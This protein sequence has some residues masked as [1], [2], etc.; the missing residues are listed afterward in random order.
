[1]GQPVLFIHGGPGGGCS[2]KH[3]QFFDPNFYRII[4]FDQ[5]GAGRSEPHACL[6]NNTT[7]H[8]VED[9]EALRRHLEIESWVLFGGSWGSTLALI[10]AQSYPQVVKALILRGIFLCR[11]QDID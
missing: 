5:R 8:L 9:I 6:Q 2:P 10:Y 4:L 1:M 3:R 7:Q 11:D